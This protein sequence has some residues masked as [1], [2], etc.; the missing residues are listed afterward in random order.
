VA[1]LDEAAEREQSASPS[2]L[3]GRIGWRARPRRWRPSA[4]VWAE[5]GKGTAP[6]LYQEI[7]DRSVRCRD[8]FVRLQRRWIVRRPGAGLLPHRTFPRCPKSATKYACLHA[9]G[10]ETANIHLGTTQPRVLRADLKK[11]P[12]GWLLEAARKNGKG[13]DRRF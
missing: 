11:R 10:W 3:A 2:R 4:C 8:P 1:A 9:M 12:S 7:L 5:E 13:G 6:I